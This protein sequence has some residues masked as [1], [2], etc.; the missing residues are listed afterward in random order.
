[1]K[2]HPEYDITVLLR[3]IPS[4][5]KQRYPKVNIVEGDYDDTTTIRDAASKADV[6]VSA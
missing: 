5:F 2:E 1:M 3:N 6:V 4:D